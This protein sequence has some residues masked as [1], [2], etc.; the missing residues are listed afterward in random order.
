MTSIG[1]NL[2]GVSYYSTQEPFID[3]AKTA[4]GWR[5]TN[6]SV[7]VDMN[8]AGDPMGIPSGS[9][10]IYKMVG[11]DPAGEAPIDT[12]VMTWQGSGTFSLAG[13][14]ILS[15]SDNQIT[16]EV[17]K[18]DTVS[19]QL[20][21]SNM[22][23]GDP[24]RD[25]H[26]VR[27]DQ[28]DLFQ[29]G[30]IFN[31]AFVEKASA[32]DVLRFKDWG[33]IDPGKAVSWDDRSQVS[34]SSW[35]KAQHADGVPL[36]VMVRLANETGTAMWWNV[37]GQADDTYV[38]NA[39]SYIRDHLDPGIKLHVEYSNE[40]WNWDYKVASYAQD[41]ASALW[42]KDANGDG[43]ID[44]KDKAE[45]PNGA[46][47]TYYG[48]RSAQVAKM[49][50]EV[51]G[52][53]A[54]AR[55]ESVLGGQLG[56]DGLF[57]YMQKGITAA[58]GTVS[59]LFDS[60]AVTTYFGNQLSVSDK[61]A[62]NQAK[63]LEWARG[64]Q[65]GMDAA[66]KELEQGGPLRADGGMSQLVSRLTKAAGLA[67]ANGLDLQAY[68]GGAHLT[69][70]KFP[71][72]IQGE[73][74]DFFARLMNDP[75][76][77][78][79]Y[80]RMADIFE[81]V[82][83]STLVSY[84]DVG[85]SDKY[86]YWGV[87]DNIYKTGSVRYDALIGQQMTG[88]SHLSAP[89][90]GF[91]SARLEGHVL[92][93]T[94]GDDTLMAGNAN[95]TI[96]GGDGNDRILGLS[97]TRNG[98]GNFIE[99]DYYQGGG[100]SDTILGGSGNDHIYGN[101]LTTSAGNADGGDLLLGGGGN[102]YIQGNA[103][104]DTIMGGTGNDRVYGGADDDL[105]NGGDG[106]DYLQ[107]NRGN[108]TLNGDAGDDALRGGAGNDLL[109]GGTGDDALYGDMGRDTLNG[110]SGYDRLTG[111]GGEDLF[112][113]TN[114]DAVFGRSGDHAY[115]GDRVADFA[116]GADHFSL[117]FA[118]SSVLHATASSAG[119]AA[120]LAARMVSGTAVAAV[121]VGSDTYLFFDGDTRG[122][123][124]SSIRFEGV[125]TNAFDVNDFV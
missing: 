107:G 43:R 33:N 90:A 38:R 59:G 3:R 31:P 45:L 88:G 111:G 60:Y 102:D 51:F 37:P 100:G 92:N 80:T 11:V 14:K 44:P 36:E 32:W 72:S 79:L 46:W 40:V 118:V 61:N 52:S 121:S 103:G 19:V 41:Q 13:A 76:M 27:T 125:G 75:R 12:Y 98:P 20:K 116:D 67:K 5:T 39:L 86:G 62:A 82:G 17:T 117:G 29:A 7:N 15:K 68:E 104:N 56:N 4:D 65:A 119:D 55:T 58:G 113:F 18:P 24:L 114:G 8:D 110:G 50:D 77:G 16:F 115:E 6:N 81:D 48:Y 28:V 85:D 23:P 10:Y 74:T 64:G 101:A 21:L 120:A 112:V 9:N 89:L 54:D 106:L 63:V 94:S 99:A 70:A 66:F 47:M 42:G 96:H 123:V 73:I 93:G 108:D 22:N 71:A 97:D 124:D 122:G 35:A 34:D 83:G 69:A 57:G 109:F 91:Q 105:I 78:N 26:V 49:V 25:L 2:T 87:L 30:E 84:F 95:D 53:S 1:M